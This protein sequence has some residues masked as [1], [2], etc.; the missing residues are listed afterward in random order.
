MAIRIQR[1]D[2][3]NCINFIGSTAPAYWNACLSAQINEG[4]S[5]RVDIIND[6]R[7]AN[8]PNTQYEFYAQDYTD[9]ADKDGNV[10]TSA[11]EMVD[12]V[13]ANANVLGISDTG[14]DLTGEDVNFRLDQTSTSIIM[15]NGA[16]FGVNTIKAVADTDGTIHIHAIGAGLPNGSEEA[17]THKHYERLEHTRVSINGVAQ[18]GGLN[19][20]VNELNELF[21]V[22]AF[23][24]VVISDPHSTMVADVNGVTTGYSLVGTDA[25]DPSGDDIFGNSSSSNYAGLL[26]DTAI[27]RA[28][29]YFT[30]DIRNEAQIGFG[31]VHTQDSFDDNHYTGS[32]TYADP[33]TFAVGNSAH[34]GFQ[35]SHWFH[36]TPDGPWTNYGASTGYVQGPGWYSST[37]RFPAS[38]E[39]ADWKAG[40]PVKMKVGIDANSFIEI[41]YYDVSES[42]WVMCARSSYPVVEGASYRLGVKSSNSIGRVASVPK[43]HELAEE[44]TAPTTLGDQSITV[45]EDNTGDITGTLAGGITSVDTI[46]N[47]NDGFV[48]TE[49]ISAIGDY[50]QFEWSAGDA[51]VG[52]FSEQNHDVADLQA[53]RTSWNNERYIYFGARTENNGELNSIYYEGP[54]SHTTLAPTGGNGYGRVGFD[55]QGRAKLWYSSDGITWT[56]YKRLN[57]SAP[58]GTYKFIWVAQSG[59]AA[60]LNSLTKGTMSFAPTMNFRYIESPDGYY[61]FPL[62]A[63]QEE[64]DYYELTVS[65]SNNGSHTHTYDDDPT[66]TTWYMPSTSNQ[67]NYGLTPTEDG[68]TTFNSNPI[69]WTEITSQTN[70]DLVPPV[71]T[72]ATLTVDE[73]ASINYQ[74]QP[75]D[76]AYTTTFSGLEGVL[77]TLIDG[78]AGMLTG[79]APEVAQDNVA[80]PSDTYTVQ[81]IR[82]NSYGSSTGTLTIVVNNLTAP[83][84]TIAGFTHIAGSTALVDSTTLADGSAV[85][86]DDVVSDGNRIIFSNTW[87]QT[88][89]RDNLQSGDKAF[90]GLARVSP[91]PTWGSIDTPDFQYGWQFE[92]LNGGT[93]LYV[94]KILNGSIVSNVTYSNF[95]NDLV[96]YHDYSVSGYLMSNFPNGG[97]GTGV[98]TPT[99]TNNE[100]QLPNGNDLTFIVASVGNTMPISASGVSENANPVVSTSLTSF[101]KALDFSG[102]SERAAQV[103]Q[104]S[105]RIPMKMNGQASLITGTPTSGYTSSNASAKPWAT[106]VVFKIDGNSSNQHIWNCG[107]GAGDNDDN[108]YL[109][110]DAAQNLYFGWGRSGALNECRIAT[111]ISSAFWYAVYIGHDGRR[112]ASAGATPGNLY[113]TFDIRMMSSHDSFA[114]SWDAGDYNAWNQAS[115]TTGGRMDRGFTG[116]MTI[117]GRGA[118]RN[119]HGKV[120]SFVTTTLRRGQPMPTTAEIEMMI[121]DPVRWLW[122]YKEGEPFR[123]PWQAGDAG[124]NFFVG[125]GSSSYSTQVWL[126]GDGNNDSYSNM[127]RNRVLSSD[128]NYTKLNLISMVS[129]DIQNV[130]IPGLS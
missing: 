104:D 129:N 18:S 30:F 51:N 15:D 99:Y 101:S 47:S 88:N 103:T 53:D 34:Y 43:I 62:F 21:T 11:Q 9:F 87:L 90:I 118:N 100:Y 23:T 40:N 6:I 112:W 27:S 57:Q 10:F 111:A 66:G 130:T 125:D 127:I 82:T 59:D 65:G 3:G 44:A 75:Q 97:S 60:N 76:T 4:D 61:N 102:S 49:T 96:F 93:S 74:T 116:E 42:A 46:T 19:D 92:Y 128:Q 55:E 24:S 115:S 45:F 41:A 58:T 36:P 109:R 85:T 86:I 8:D 91:T 81:V 94:R 56:A 79:T 67:M 73:L 84:V 69:T 83:T 105:N 31:L 110:V 108:I 95:T 14:A 26:S 89:I 106:A 120:A 37:L 2:A 32:A 16:A 121:T 80:N 52:L 12:Y 50:F 20:V 78:G 22:G 77:D 39:V 68:V 7:S 28:G 29:E 123:L 71:F 63:T 35:F 126:M 5:S 122:D 117:G 64:A 38:A 98:A 124:W 33:A 1:N 119:F 70:A 17:D 113:T 25:V 72:A 114:T 54:A 48:S 107:E 13:N